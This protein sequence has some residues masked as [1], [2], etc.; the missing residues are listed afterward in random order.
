MIEFDSFL[1]YE[2]LDGKVGTRNYV[3]ILA[4]THAAHFLAHKIH[5]SVNGTKVFVPEDEDGRSREDRETIRRV[6]VGLG[7][8]PN[9]H[10]VLLIANS[11]DVSYEE[12]SVNQIAEDISKTGKEVQVLSIDLCG[13]MY[14]AMGKGVRIARD[15]LLTASKERRTEASISKLLLGVKCGL[16]DSTSGIAGNP[17]VGAMAD[18]LIAVGGSLIFSETTEVVGAEHFIANRSV[19]DAV[20]LKFL[21]AVQQAEDRAI[22]IGED[23]RSINPIPANIK[24]GITTLEEKS[25]GA[26]AKAGHSRLIDVIRYAEQPKE[27]GL[28]F[29]DSWMSSTTLFLGYAA[30]GATVGIFQMGGACLP[31]HPVVPA[32]ATGIITPIMYVTG[33]PQ[34]FRK[35]EMDFNAGVV[36]E[37]DEE[38]KDVGGSLMKKV[39]DIASGTLTEAETLNYQ[40]RVEIYLTGPKL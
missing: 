30:S 14:S 34:T 10:S 25:M 22:S 27:Q 32:V 24:A 8:N 21:A 29:M 2:R 26:I 13:G 40:D 1:G 7:M 31:D 9:V 12:L 17:V 39:I 3:L 38:I 37:D 4:T 36:I 28:F 15:L 23:I 11:M 16:S 18:R 20:R 5:E 19:N 35:G 6:L 33:N